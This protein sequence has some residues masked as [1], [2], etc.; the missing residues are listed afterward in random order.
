MINAYPIAV[1]PPIY[2]VITFC[3]VKDKGKKKREMESGEKESGRERER[4]RDNG[5]REGCVFCLLVLRYVI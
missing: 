5:G 2:Q 3:K 1:T 4:E